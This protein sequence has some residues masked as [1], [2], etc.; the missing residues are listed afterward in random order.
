M[1]WLRAGPPAAM[2]PQSARLA[3]GEFWFET[4]LLAQART[5]PER[6]ARHRGARAGALR[7][8]DRGLS[9]VRESRGRYK[10]HHFRLLLIRLLIDAF[11]PDGGPYLVP[12]LAE[13]E[14]GLN[15]PSARVVYERARSAQ[16][17][18]LPP[19]AGAPAVQR[20][21]PGAAASRCIRSGLAAFDVA[22]AWQPAGRRA[23]LRDRRMTDPAVAA[24]AER[25]TSSRPAC[26]NFAAGAPRSSRRAGSRPADPLRPLA[27]VVVRRRDPA[28][29]DR[30]LLRA[31]GPRRRLPDA[32][33][34]RPA[35][36]RDPP[37][38]DR[39]QRLPAAAPARTDRAA[40]PGPRRAGQHRIDAAGAHGPIDRGELPAA[41]RRRLDRLPRVVH[42]GAH[43]Q[44]PVRRAAIRGGHAL[45]RQVQSQRRRGCDRGREL[46]LPATFR[47]YDLDA[48]RA[49]ATTSNVLNTDARS[50]LAG[51][52]WNL[53]A[54]DRRAVR[55]A[56]RREPSARSCALPAAPRR[57]PTTSRRR[58]AG[59]AAT[60]AR[61][62]IRATFGAA[63]LGACAIGSSSQT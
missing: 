57:P 51:L 24:R 13:L 41:T 29:S 31:R 30:R 1:N 53:L 40:L 47:W 7:L 19:G 34:R 16:L 5:A 8:G 18:G 15:D 3:E 59:V 10:D 46:E 27:R 49:F 48:I 17:P 60:P 44:A 37:A 4:T 38:G 63:A 12:S 45:L 52:D 21:L 39:D 58:A 28:A 35:A 26:S 33:A 25:P 22:Y 43:G 11:D 20:S 32:G 50:V 14:R 62:R 55:A 54:D 2:R 9:Q 36:A 61:S 6:I 56:R 23:S 42:R